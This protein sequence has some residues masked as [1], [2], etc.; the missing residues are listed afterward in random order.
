M[1]SE[2]P[3]VTIEIPEKDF[4]K[5]KFHGED[6]YRF[7]SKFSGSW[8]YPADQV[9]V[10]SEMR[11]DNPKCKYCGMSLP[12]E[13][14]TA[15]KDCPNPDCQEKDFKE[16]IA[17][18]PCVY[19]KLEHWK[20]GCSNKIRDKAKRYCHCGIKDAQNC[21]F[22]KSKKDKDADPD[23]VVFDAWVKHK[24]DRFIIS[25]NNKLFIKGAKDCLLGTIS[26]IKGSCTDI[27]SYG[28]GIG[29]MQEALEKG[30]IFDIKKGDAK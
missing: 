17:N 13:T 1:V 10:E 3:K 16:Y 29:D 9:T 11:E 26:R 4:E 22:F 18:F 25:I 19:R 21:P 15:E 14:F 2:M 6:A 30:L 24:M 12:I 23:I 27:H 5:A 28:W 20:N 7:W 8:Y